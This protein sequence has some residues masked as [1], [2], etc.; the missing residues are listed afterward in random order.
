MA[1][2]S[3]L[4]VFS[5]I[6]FIVGITLGVVCTKCTTKTSRK[7]TSVTT[8]LPPVYEEVSLPGRGQ[9]ENQSPLKITSN[10]AYGQLKV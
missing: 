8:P 6:M 10:E 5:I 7:K 4:L 2:T 1:V 9:S 3:S